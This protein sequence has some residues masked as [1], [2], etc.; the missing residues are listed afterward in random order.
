MANFRMASA[1]A[2]PTVTMFH[3]WACFDDPIQTY[4]DRSSLSAERVCTCCLVGCS[5][6]RDV[7]T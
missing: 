7:Q 4:N 6:R 2:L 1:C 3:A 5:N